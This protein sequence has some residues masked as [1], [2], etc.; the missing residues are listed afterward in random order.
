MDVRHLRQE[1]L[2]GAGA[3]DALRTCHVAV[4]GIGGVGSYT[5][6]ALAR[7]GIGEITLVDGDVYAESNF[8]RQLYATE[9]TVGVAKVAAAAKR[10]HTIN[11]HIKV[12]ERQIFFLPEC[13]ADFDFS[14][15]DYVI[16]AVD[17]VAAKVAIAERAYRAGVPAV[18]CMG[19]GNKTDPTLFR[20]A[21]IYKTDVCPLARAVRTALRRR[22]VPKLK[23]VYSTE[24]PYAAL[25]ARD[26]ETGKPA[27]ASCAFVP[28][29]AGM[30]LAGEAV[31]D[32]LC[33]KLVK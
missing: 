20:V 19:T 13:A 29:V 3:T 9:D 5:V 15:F 1:M 25:L 12:H 2:F 10:I 33:R 31:K 24:P 16:D 17:T 11:P 14:R 28:P 30:I 23:T 32:L 4:F 18:S 22:G 26:E 6:E 27:P 8:N 21:D 7:S